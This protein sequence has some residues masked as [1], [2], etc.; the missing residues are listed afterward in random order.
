MEGKKLTEKQALSKIASYFKKYQEIMLP[1]VAYLDQITDEQKEVFSNKLKE[2][3]K[4]LITEVLMFYSCESLLIIHKVM[5]K[6]QEV[7]KPLYPLAL[8][9]FVEFVYSNMF[10]ELF[11]LNFNSRNLKKEDVKEEDICH[12]DYMVFVEHYKYN[13]YKDAIKQLKKANALTNSL[14]K[15]I[16]MRCSNCLKK[17]N[18][19]VNI[20]EPYTRP[21]DITYSADKT[22]EK[23]KIFKR[24]ESF[25][26]LS[27]L[28][29]N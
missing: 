3:Q 5:N 10:Y 17:I 16:D 8:L 7:T 27:F 6:A 4:K 21:K 24:D 29:I 15:T 23:H 22:I 18:V 9:D 13:C 11:L 28:P 26:L 20:L 25:K 14:E 1:Y 12:F 2:L 19:C